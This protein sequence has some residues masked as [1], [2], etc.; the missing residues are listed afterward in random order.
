MKTFLIIFAVTLG[1]LIVASEANSICPGRC[2]HIYIPPGPDCPSCPWELCLNCTYAF[3]WSDRDCSFL[4]RSPTS[5]QLCVGCLPSGP[6]GCVMGG[7][8]CYLFAV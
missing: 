2:D 5:S 1:L 8:T 7:D 3:P 6:C 4:S